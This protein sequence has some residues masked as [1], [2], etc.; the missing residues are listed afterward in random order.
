VLVGSSFHFMSGLSVY[1]CRLANALVPGHRVGVLLLDRLIPARLYPGGARVGQSLA[2]LDYDAGV[3][4]GARIDWWGRGLLRALRVLRRDRPRLLVLQ[5]WTAATLHTYLVLA[6]AAR[7]LGI[8]VVVEFHETQDT[9]EA[10]VPFV[11]S[12][13]RLLVPRLLRLAS[14]AVVHHDHDLQ[15]IRAAYGERTLAHL[16]I[17]VAPHGPYDHL[18]AA[19]PASPAPDDEPDDGVTRLLFFGTIRPYKGLEDLVRVFNRLSPEVARTFHLAVVGETWEGWTEPAALIE[20]SPHRDRITFVNHYVT[21]DEAATHLAAAD[22]M[23]LPARRGSASGPLAIAMSSGL[24][25]VMYAVPG[26]AEA[27]KDYTGVTLVD[28]D[29][30]DGLERALLDVRA[31]RAERH[32]DPHSWDG[33]VGAV[34]RLLAALA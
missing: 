12:Y 15:A 34:D 24:N 22:V 10:S 32:A 30:L 3:Q 8:P 5:W 18:G 27:A 25:V 13:A 31:R 11:G 1:T 4:V 9:G 7:R 28:P 19:A 29:D 23:V 14:G 16:A 21:D 6:V 20:A 26:L 33:A 17:E 2:S